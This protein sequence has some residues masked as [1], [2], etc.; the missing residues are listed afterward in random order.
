[1]N[2]VHHWFKNQYII[3]VIKLKLVGTE[4]AHDVIEVGG[5][6]SLRVDGEDH[7]LRVERSGQ[8]ELNI[9]ELLQE[10]LGNARSSSF[11]SLD[12]LLWGSLFTVLQNKAVHVVFD[13]RFEVSGGS[14]LGLSVLEAINDVVDS[15]SS[16]I[17][18]FIVLRL[19]TESIT[20]TN[21][22]LISVLD[23]VL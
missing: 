15:L 17:N 16:T 12:G 10:E 19:T 20:A 11:E 3:Y 7:G 4:S 8:E 22:D 13:P 5:Q 18:T 9:T 23:N 14:D 6:S 2:K 21:I 1:M